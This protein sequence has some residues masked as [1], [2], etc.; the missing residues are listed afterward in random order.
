MSNLPPASTDTLVRP[1]LVVDLDRSLIRVDLL[2]EAMARLGL[3]SPLH[4][5]RLAWNH[6]KSLA[7]FKYAV[8]QTVPIDVSKL[9]YEPHVITYLR[10][11]SACGRRMILA[12]ASP[13]IW[14]E[15]IAA[16]LGLF[17]DVLATDTENNLK[18]HRKLAAVRELLDDM[19]FAY[20]GDSSDDIPLFEAASGG[21][22]LAGSSPQALAHLGRSGIDFTHVAPANRAA[23]IRDMIRACRPVHWIKNMLIFV[24]A[25]TSWG[26]YDPSRLIPAVFAFFS[27]VVRFLLTR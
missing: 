23:R 7:A 1:P 21:R 6:R 24:P 16:H 19:P 18:S 2:H 13:A 5:L 8:A 14:A 10:E 9:P 26:M 15:P 11:E 3:R 25:V 22:V 17:S 27:A 12:T 4:L 20:L